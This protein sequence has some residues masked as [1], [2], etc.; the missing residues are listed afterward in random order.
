AQ[1]QVLAAPIH[2]ELTGGTEA[3]TLH[4]RPAY[5]PAGSFDEGAWLTGSLREGL[6][7]EFERLRPN[8]LRRGM[9]LTGPQRDDLALQIN[10]LELRHYGSRGQNRTAM[11]AFKLAQ[12]DWLRQRTGEQPVLLLDEVLAELDPERRGYLLKRLTE[13]NQALLTAADI[14]MFNKSFLERATRWTIEAG[15]LSA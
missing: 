14:G 6:Q 1:F 5:E 11:L 9:T 8:E 4:Y 2:E 15:S 10:G 7:A 3:L 12:V 13:S